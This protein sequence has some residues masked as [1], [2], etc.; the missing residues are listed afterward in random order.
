MSDYRALPD[1]RTVK[2]SRRAYDKVRH[3]DWNGKRSPLHT[4]A[5][6]ALSTARLVEFFNGVRDTGRQRP[7]VVN[8]YVW[9][10]ELAHGLT[11]RVEV[12]VEYDAS[13]DWSDY[14]YTPTDKPDG[15]GGALVLRNPNAWRWDGEEWVRTDRRLCGWIVCENGWTRAEEHAARDVVRKLVNGGY[16]FFGVAVKV[17]V[18]D[19]SLNPIAS[20][21]DSLS[22]VMAESAADPYVFDT[23]A[24][25]ADVA[26]DSAVKAA[27]ETI[28]RYARLAGELAG[29]S[30]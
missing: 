12:T 14:G 16:G 9:T 8:A 25:V 27:R 2:V 21:H 7:N 3:T 23:A 4:S 20:G 26:L 22:G 13:A 18:L 1:L 19:A 10:R 30:F 24:E 5:K 15:H 28:A 17:T 11:A 6:V 29:K